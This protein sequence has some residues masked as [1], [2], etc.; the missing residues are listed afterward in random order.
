MKN[1]RELNTIRMIL[2]S[3]R[4]GATKSRI[5]HDVYMSSEKTGIYLS[6]LIKHKLLKCE[7][8]NKTY[9]TTEKGFQ[10]LDESSEINEFIHKSESPFSDFDL[11]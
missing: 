9:H 5:M 7:L 8:G 2:E 3:A 1:R 10:I 4:N 6:F 11:L